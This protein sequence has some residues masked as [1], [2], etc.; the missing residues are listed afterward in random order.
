MALF[1]LSGI[2][3][4]LNTVIAG[5][6]LPNEEEQ[7]LAVL[8]KA[9]Q[10]LGEDPT[11]II[12]E[13]Q[14]RIEAIDDTVLLE[15]FA[16]LVGAL[17]LTE[18]RIVSISTVN[19]LPDAFTLPSGSVFFVD[20]LGVLVMAVG[21]KWL[22]LDGRLLRED[23]PPVDAMGW[24]FSVGDGTSISRSSP[25]TVVGGIT[26][27]SQVSAGA[28]HIL[29]I[30]RDGIAYGWRTATDGR[31]GDGTT[32][33]KSSPVT[34]VGGITNWSQVSA[35]FDH[36]LGVT[37]DGIAY[38]W[39][40][41]VGGRL[42]DG[43]A[44]SKNSPVT[45][46]GGITNWSSISCNGSNT[47]G[48]SIGIAGGIAYSWGI[49]FAGCLGDGTSIARSSPV[50]VVGGITNWSQVSAG[51]YH[52]LGVTADGIAYAWGAGGNGTL[53]VGAN[54]NRSSPVTVVG[55]ITNW[56]Q[57]SAGGIH[58]L[59]VTADGIAYAW[60]GGTHGRLGDG[61]SNSRN[62]P[63]TVVGGITNWSQVSAGVDHSLGVTADGIAYGWGRGVDG[64]IGDGFTNISRSSPV[65]VVGGIT[66][67]SSVSAG[68]SISVGIKIQ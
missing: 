39:G 56:S 4:D 44:V 55:G 53:G 36:S 1:D 21:N 66:N 11:G 20:S 13:L 37:A 34:V 24:G 42:G 35:G 7:R 22:G 47:T 30:T 29:G 8:L 18:D 54:V 62:S 5:L 15:K 60:G 46:V 58:S 45:V 68:S 48:H 26:N 67:W 31:L 19:D 33:S 27:W 6:D 16:V 52:I 57:V 63:V 51:G 12:G 38:A 2:V 32:I 50:T 3:S 65:T 23:L 9:A 17:G 14:T 25:V 64:K 41:G 28:F 59:G 49:N 43:T 10:N 61:T 40:R